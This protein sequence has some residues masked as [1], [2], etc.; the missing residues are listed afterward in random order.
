MYVL[1]SIKSKWW[2]KIR[3]G[4]KTFEI[5]TNFPHKVGWPFRILWYETGGVGIVGESTC[6]MIIIRCAPYKDLAKES[7][8]TSEELKEYGRGK[9]LYGWH[10]SKT[11]AYKTPIPLW[12]RPPQSWQYLTMDWVSVKDRLPLK[13]IKNPITNGY[14]LFIC[15]LEMCGKRIQYALMYDADGHW[16][17]QNADYTEDVLAWRPM[18]LPYCEEKG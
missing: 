7:C 18:P 12:V 16:I 14:M 9:D 15:D 1:V 13:G 11:I 17:S 3:S 10:I 8:L 5:R 4:E 2:E 6:D